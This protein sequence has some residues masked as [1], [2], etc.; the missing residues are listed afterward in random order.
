[1]LTSEGFSI[2]LWDTLEQ[3]NGSE[4]E[5][6]QILFSMPKQLLI[7]FDKEFMRALSNL[8]KEVEAAGPQPH[9]PFGIMSEDMKKDLFA[10][11][12]SRGARYYDDIL[13]YPERIPCNVGPN[14]VDF[15]G[16]AG[17]VYSERFGDEIAL[18]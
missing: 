9:S 12:V 14:D 13:H 2:L 6:R 15:Q 8:W 5:L 18:Q 11:V 1:M 4:E 3:A 10:H 16:I 7:S 17:Q